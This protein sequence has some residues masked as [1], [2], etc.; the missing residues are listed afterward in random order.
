MYTTNKN[1]CVEM[2]VP[3]AVLKIL[4]LRFD[5]LSIGKNFSFLSEDVAASVFRS[6]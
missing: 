2:E 4:L 5:D 1:D 3:T 6:V